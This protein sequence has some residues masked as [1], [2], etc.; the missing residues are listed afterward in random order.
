MLIRDK[1]SHLQQDHSVFIVQIIIAITVIIDYSISNTIDT[2]LGGLFY[3][4]PL[5]GIIPT[6]FFPVG[7]YTAPRVRRL[8]LILHHAI[9]A[10]L[11]I[12]FTDVFGPYFQLLILLLF[13]SAIWNGLRGIVASLFVAYVTVGIASWYQFQGNMTPSQWYQLSLYL[14][15][16][17]VLGL[18]F[19]RVTH[20]YR[21]DTERQDEANQSLY[22]ERTRLLSLINSMADAVVATDQQGKVLLYNGAAL[23]L[24]N[25]NESLY[26]QSLE[27]LVQLKQ[28]NGE[29]FEVIAAAQQAS[30]TLVRD[31]I[32]FRA[33]DESEI[34]INLSVSPVSSPGSE[35]S[36]A[37]FIFVLRDITKQKT[38]DEQRDEFISTASHELRT[39]IA[40][41]EAN[42]STA[43]MPKF[44]DQLSEEG[45]K[46]LEQ[47][48]ENV[49]FLSNLVNDLHVLAQ[50]EKGRLE[51]DVAEVDPADFLNRL[52]DDY[53]QQATAKG[54]KFELEVEKAVRPITTSLDAVKEIMQNFITNAIKY[55]ETGTVT[56]I[57]R[58]D[59]EGDGVVFAVKDSGIGISAS[60]QKHIFEKFYRSEDYRTRQSGGTGLGL[61]ITKR[62]VERM[63]GR[64]WFESQLNKGSTFYCAL[65]A[66]PMLADESPTG[67]D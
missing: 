48:H 57:A 24:F 6:L 7:D 13:T 46:L 1:L 37:G 9:V 67:T 22:F 20:N 41:A 15:G 4:L 10:V 14:V 39:P 31:D 26:N 28:P 27:H 42:I 25:T 60:D 29:P 62:L 2:N 55:T 44:A 63:G 11:L 65:P 12:F 49:L 16:L 17:T 33:S 56:L 34:D 19:E 40:I 32:Y 66:E 38:L 21:R 64:L 18:L 30:G 45:R 54:L 8:L 53:R 23:E 36:R 43:M 61:Y 51:I 50:A 35:Q 47:A 59:S 52:Q 5:L 3:I 58:A